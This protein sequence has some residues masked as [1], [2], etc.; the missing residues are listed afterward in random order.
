MAYSAP[1]IVQPPSQTGDRAKLWRERGDSRFEEQSQHLHLWQVIAELFYPERADFTTQW[2]A[3]DERYDG[4]YTSAPQQMRRDL[5]STLGA[6][7][8]PRGRQWFKAVTRPE[9]LMR[10]ETVKRWCEQA[11]HTQWNI[12]YDPDA[13]FTNAM[14]QSDADYVTFGNSVVSHV[15]HPNHM[16]L[17][18]KCE[19]LR[20]CAWAENAA[21]TIDEMHN[22]M[23]LTLRQIATLFGKDNMPKTWRDRLDKHPG[24]KHVVRRCVAPVDDYMYTPQE[25]SRRM[26][27]AQFMSIYIAEDVKED[28]CFLGE[29]YFRTFPYTVR[30]WMTVSGENYGRSLCTGIA[31]ADGRTLNVAQ[32]D[33]LKGIEWKVNPPRVTPHDSLVGEVRLEAGSII[34]TAD[35][36][37]ER[38]GEHLRAL[39][40]GDPR[41]GM[42]LTDR[43]RNDMGKAFFQDVLKYLPD[44]E[45]TAFEVGERLEMFTA[46]AAPIFEPMEAENAHMMES[47]FVRAMDKGAFGPEETW[48][49]EFQEESA[50]VEFEFE[51]PLSDALRKRAVNQYDQTLLRAGQTAELFPDALDN[52]DA[53][54]AFR[55]VIESDGSMKWLRTEKD[56]DAARAARLERQRQQ[57]AQAVAL[58]AGKVAGS[59]NPENIRMAKQAIEGS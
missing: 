56:R 15:Y 10:I 16:G 46:E 51:T 29:G 12:V 54:A 2:S 27:G 20:D 47:V 45:M 43:I 26:A 9:Q 19:H 31:L 24:E 17:L 30:R 37:D 53:D 11:S 59:A 5:S 44:R 21:G 36:Y 50:Q 52:F 22:R 42:E 28:E 25:R 55:E 41:Y 38:S 49:I 18:F 13:K 14:A 8:R 39:E 35:E 40:T 58:E 7:L 23:R 3:G 6:M 32:A 57:E 4:I 33:L 34:Y 48:P 1:A